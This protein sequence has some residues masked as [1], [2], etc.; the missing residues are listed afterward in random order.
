MTFSGS[1]LLLI[2]LPLGIV[3]GALGSLTGIGGGFLLMP[4]LLILLPSAPQGALS[5]VTLL[6]VFFNALSGTILSARKERVRFRTGLAYG[7]LSLPLVWLGTHLQAS[8]DRSTF[9]WA[10]GLLLVVGGGFLLFRPPLEDQGLR[11]GKRIWSA[12][13]AVALVIG[14][15]SGFFGVGGG[16]LFVPLL[17][18]VL[19][20][21]VVEATATS[22]LIVGL[23][24]AW[25]LAT[26]ALSHPLP[27][28]PLLVAGLV[29]GVLL[30]SPLG[31]TLAG[32]LK[33]G[34]VLKVLAVLLLLASA[35]FLVPW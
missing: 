2:G 18:F 26:G 1:L 8:V 19:R 21:P 24:A 35:K 12:G 11:T 13:A 34:G 23:G 14:L 10:F 6:V 3:L 28:N 20:F 30:G 16:F 29:A 31:T 4:V 22:Q 9:A 15:V 25:A 27:L 32:R 7:L 5:V 17:A 33:P